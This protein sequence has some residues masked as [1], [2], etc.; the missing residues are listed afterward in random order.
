MQIVSVSPGQENVRIQLANPSDFAVVH[1]TAVRFMPAFDLY[2]DLMVSRMPLPEMVAPGRATSAF[3]TGRDIGDEYRYVLNRKD[4]RIFPGNMLDRPGLILNPWALRQTQTGVLR[5]QGGENFRRMSESDRGARGRGPSAEEDPS[6]QAGIFSNLNFLAGQAVVLTNLV[7]DENGR[8]EIPRNVL[9]D[10][11]HLHVVAADPFHY[12]YRSLVLPEPDASYRDLR[13]RDNLDPSEHLIHKR[14]IEALQAGESLQIGDIKTARVE[15]Y[16]SLPT[17]YAQYLSLVDDPKL[18]DFAFLMNWPELTPEQKREKYSSHACHELHFFL[19]HKDPEFF[20]EVIKPYLANKKDKTFLDHYLIEDA[21]ALRAYLQPWAY[22][23]LNV[24]ERVLLG[25]ALPGQVPHTREH[26]RDLL[27]TLEPGA[28]QWERYFRAGLGGR[29]LSSAR[30]EL[31]PSSD[32]IVFG[33]AEP[34]PT[35]PARPSLE[36]AVESI[37]SKEQEELKDK[38]GK[39]RRSRR[40]KPGGDRRPNSRF[41]GWDVKRTGA[42]SLYRRL[43]KTTEWAENNYYKLRIE[44]QNASLIDINEFWKDYAD[45][46]GQGAFLS[47]HFSQASGNAAEALLALAVTDLPFQADEHKVKSENDARLIEAASPA[48]VFHQQIQPVEKPD[49]DKTP[50]LISQNFFRADDRYRRENNQRV[51]KFVTEEFLIQVVYGGQVVVTNPTSS[52]HSLD[53][54]VQIPAGAMPVN[55]GHYTDTVSVTLQPYSTHRL[56]YFFYFPAPG[57]FQHYPVHVSREQVLLA[58][59]E[60]FAFHVVA[61]P[62]KVDTQSWAYVSQYGSKEEVIEFLENHNPLQLSLGQIAWRMKEESFFQRTLE[63]LSK[64]HVYDHTLWGYGFMHND[65]GAVQ[66]YLKHAANFVSKLG[67]YV[68]SP[69]LRIDPVVRRSYQHLEYWPLVNARRHRLGPDRRIPNQRIYEQYTSLLEILKRKTQ[70]EPEDQ[71]A[72]VYYLLLQD[73]VAEAIER[74]AKIDPEAL[75]TRLQYDCFQVYIA[76]YTE[77]LEKARRIVR[78]YE[79]YPV[80]RWRKIFANAAAQLDQIEGKQVALVDPEDRRQQQTRQVARQPA[81][82]LKVENRQ[83]TLNYQNVTQAKVNYYLMDIE[84]LF[85][86]SPFVKGTSKQFSYVEPNFT[87]TVPLDAEAR[88]HTF[89][90]P[91]RFH[92]A[93]VLV[94][95]EAGPVTASKTYFA[96]SMRVQVIESYGQLQVTSARTGKGLSKVYVKVYARTPGGE[97]FFKDGYTDLRGRFDYTSLSSD[98]IKGVSRFAILVLSKQHGALIREAA[99]PQR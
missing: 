36:N 59:A 9:G 39:M 34:P 10:K 38:A 20:K 66:E 25:K 85:S 27:G 49:A 17:L 46:Q 45:H 12:V 44:D 2:G 21:Q 48:I 37:I 32:G 97:K 56:E 70:L 73:R 62:S 57:D 28:L 31:S 69:L 60:A 54:L 71:M 90:L 8:I 80:P 19:S 95:V 58:S 11:H 84:L 77:E 99:P 98:E 74:F 24:A 87:Q 23:Q 3:V 96:N 18:R 82:E 40:K 55:A 43:E 13:L 93:N 30:D 78:R 15:I 42:P 92:S 4:L 83:V 63:M 29:G 65:A 91:D 26:L 22:A 75:D 1:V 53:V 14:K 16:D 64:R 41:S 6:G 67:P 35:A 76:F 51:D 68:R 89:D 86:R 33:P 94:E 72:V 5:A 50:I 52:S 61:E 81:V 79:D 47:R 7:P 88:T